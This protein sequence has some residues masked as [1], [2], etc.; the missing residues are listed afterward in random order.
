MK[1]KLLL[2]IGLPL[3]LVVG[4]GIVLLL[5][6]SG[7]STREVFGRYQADFDAKR[8]DMVRLA[9]ELPAV[10]SVVA[11]V[12]KRLDPPPFYDPAS[13]KDINCSIVMAE[14]LRDPDERIRT[15]ERADFNL[16]EGYL[17]MHLQW[18]GPKNPMSPSGWEGRA[19]AEQEAEIKRVLGQPYLIVIRTV[20]YEP[21]M[22]L[23]ETTF[24]GG[25]IEMEAFV[26]DWRTKRVE[27]V[28]RASARAEKNVSVIKGK[29][30]DWIYSSMMTNARRE[31]A[32]VLA[33]VTGGT[34]NFEFGRGIGS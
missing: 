20:R 5:V 17:L 13:K 19:R 11:N 23:G 27:A 9:A 30:Q 8:R 4:G 10:G 24:R 14:Q 3:V 33:E 31:L 25:F 28:A 7:E 22:L 15:P 12:P 1:W 34:F 18:S 21:P 6:L 32:R 29:D 2:F 26:Y 16:S